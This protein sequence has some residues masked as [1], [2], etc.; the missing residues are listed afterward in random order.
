MPSFFLQTKNIVEYVKASK[1]RI[2][3]YEQQVSM[4][5]AL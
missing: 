1:A 5:V 4:D 3:E 2:A